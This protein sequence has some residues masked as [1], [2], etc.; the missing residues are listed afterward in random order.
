MVMVQN[1]ENE[2]EVK[3]YDILTRTALYL[4]IYLSPY[5]Y[6][7]LEVVYADVYVFFLAQL[8]V[9]QKTYL[10]IYISNKLLNSLFC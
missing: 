2:L 4:L 10:H 6:S 8:K 7:Y 3:Y 1:Y 5:Q 9:K